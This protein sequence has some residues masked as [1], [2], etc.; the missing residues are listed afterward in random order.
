MNE[1]RTPGAAGLMP[2]V[3]LSGGRS[4]RM[5]RPKALVRWPPTGETFLTHLVRVLREGGVGPLGVVTGAHHAEIAQAVDGL[6]V[7]L[8]FNARH[9]EGQLSSLH[10]GLAWAFAQT[11]GDWAL[12]TL[13]DVPGVAPATVAHLIDEARACDGY[14]VRPGVG[15]A[16]GH[17]VIWHRA[18]VPL[19]LEVDAS[20]GARGLV[21][22]LAAEGLVREVPVDDRGVLVDIDTAADLD[23]VRS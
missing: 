16:H 11:S 7:A 20:V 1:R 23:A 19:L 18:A 15:D 5:G 6:D 2:A 14:L 13:V 8:V 12:V 10:R 22:R 21:R 3:I 9:D 17:P 4:S